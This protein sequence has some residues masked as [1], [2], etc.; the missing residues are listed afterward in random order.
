MIK[1]KLD[2]SQNVLF[3]HESKHLPAMHVLVAVSHIDVA[4]KLAQSGVS[5]H[6]WAHLILSETADAVPQC[7][8]IIEMQT[9]QNATQN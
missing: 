6:F 9:M 8:E 3:V 7:A 2:L 4:D 1:A 5:K